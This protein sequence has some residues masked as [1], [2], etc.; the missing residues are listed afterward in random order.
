MKDNAR[1]ATPNQLAQPVDVHTEARV[2]FQNGC[3]AKT[4]SILITNSSLLLR[5]AAK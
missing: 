4:S 2:A 1:D 3:S 5:S